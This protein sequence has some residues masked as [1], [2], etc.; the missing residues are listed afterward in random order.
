MEKMESTKDEKEQLLLKLEGVFNG[1]DYEGGGVGGTQQ[2]LS[3][4]LWL[5]AVAAAATW[6][7]LMPCSPG[8]GYWRLP[9]A[10]VKFSLRRIRL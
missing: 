2:L 4:L 5:V 7:L 10:S 8:T 3:S 9:A 6:W 1:V